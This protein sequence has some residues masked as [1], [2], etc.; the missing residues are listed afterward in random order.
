MQPGQLAPNLGEAFSSDRLRVGDFTPVMS[1]ASPQIA[2][3]CFAI[4]MPGK[5]QVLSISAF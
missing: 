1:W 5:L 2:F 4:S 3:Y